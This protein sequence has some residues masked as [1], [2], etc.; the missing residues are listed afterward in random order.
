MTNLP[1]YVCSITGIYWGFLNLKILRQETQ[2]WRNC[3]FQMHP[4]FHARHTSNRSPQKQYGSHTILTVAFC[5][6]TKALSKSPTPWRLIG[7]A[8]PLKIS[9]IFDID[10]TITMLSDTSI[11][12]LQWPIRQYHIYYIWLLKY[13]IFKSPQQGRSFYT[14]DLH[15]KSF[16]FKP[17]LQDAPSLVA[18]QQTAPSLRTALQ[19]GLLEANLDMSMLAEKW[20]DDTNMESMKW[21]NQD[22]WFLWFDFWDELILVWCCFYNNNMSVGCV[23]LYLNLKS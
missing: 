2:A 4:T 19:A 5:L 15:S 23:Y 10:E 7:S 8:N 6:A 16:I 12:K 11:Q 21:L 17:W 20:T 3:I 13:T 9:N 22:I 1:P 14:G 18:L